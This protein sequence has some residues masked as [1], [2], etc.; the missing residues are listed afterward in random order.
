MK[1]ICYDCVHYRRGDIESPCA[2]SNRYAGYLKENMKC[3]EAKEGD[4][5]EDSVKKVCAKCGKLLP[6]RMFYK[7]KDTPDNLSAVCRDCNPHYWFR[8]LKKKR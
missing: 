1:N 3:W 4:I 2:K 6:L 5:E 7:K 8:K